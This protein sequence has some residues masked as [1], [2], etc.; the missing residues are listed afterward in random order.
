M[1]FTSSNPI[2]DQRNSVR[3][4]PD[5]SALRQT[6]AAIMAAVFLF[7]ATVPVLQVVAWG[8]MLWQY[9]AQSGL[10]VGFADTFSGDKPCDLC[11]I[12]QNSENE[13]NTPPDFTIQFTQLLLP[14]PEASACAAPLSPC[15]DAAKTAY[16]GSDGSVNGS[17]LDPPPKAA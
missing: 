17:D 9:S 1:N 14:P 15:V 10:S 6:V 16:S 2:A 3:A 7:C 4:R 11:R 8:T 12:V 5:R 13:Q